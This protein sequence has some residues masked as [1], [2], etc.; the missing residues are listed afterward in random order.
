MRC[1]VGHNIAAQNKDSDPA[2][3]LAL[4]DPSLLT[5]PDCHGALVQLREEGPLRFRCHTGH[6]FTANSLIASLGES[7]EDTLWSALRALHE[8]IM[9][10]RHMAGHSR[11]KREP[12]E[13]AKLMLEAR[14]MQQQARLVRKALLADDDAIERPAAREHGAK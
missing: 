8:K 2:K 6:A 10:L 12:G 7:T 5:C 14:R 13:A 3:V 1:D 9:I 4:G 11:E